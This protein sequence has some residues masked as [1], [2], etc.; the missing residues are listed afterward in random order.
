MALITCPKCQTTN[1][2]RGFPAWVIILAI[3]LFPFGLLFLLVGREP[4]KCCQCGTY[5]QT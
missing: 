3:L 1:K 5:I 4:T 2:R